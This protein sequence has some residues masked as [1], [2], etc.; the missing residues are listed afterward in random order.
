MSFITEKSYYKLHFLPNLACVGT[1]AASI[2]RKILIKKKHTKRELSHENLTE[3]DWSV[4]LEMDE[5]EL[6]EKDANYGILSQ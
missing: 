6:H 4:V 3:K 5:L 2:L 1:K